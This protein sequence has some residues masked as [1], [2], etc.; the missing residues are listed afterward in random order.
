[1]ADV[2]RSKANS[3]DAQLAD[4]RSRRAAGQEVFDTLAQ[5][6]LGRSGVSRGPMFGS[7]GLM[8]NGKF[9]AFVGRSGDLVLKLSETQT[10]AL[11]EAGEATAVRAG[12][13][14]TREWVNVPM[15]ADG[16]TDRWQKL[17]SDAYQNATRK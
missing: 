17:L 14:P 10:T 4:R 1:M 5:D 16:K 8:A 13:N 2:A 3:G 9:F 6:Y 12:R 15:A 11:V 7:E